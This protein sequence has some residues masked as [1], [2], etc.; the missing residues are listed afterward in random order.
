MTNVDQL[1]RM[2]GNSAWSIRPG[3]SVLDALKLLAEKDIGALLVVEDG[4]LVGIFSERDYARKLALKGKHSADTLVSE[5]MSSGVITVTS[6]HTI[7][8][9]MA[10]MTNERVR[11]L[12]VVVENEIVGI[13][14]IGDVVKTLIEEREKTIEQLSNY[15]TGEGYGR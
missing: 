8:D 9:C 10:I 12:P 2:K 6:H 1:L 4:K 5:V 7:D 13:V 14:S 3:A 15:I 11:H